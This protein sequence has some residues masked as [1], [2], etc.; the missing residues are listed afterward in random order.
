M[1][2]R[3]GDLCIKSIKELPMG[4]TKL[5]HNRVA[6]GEVTGHAHTLLGNDFELYQD[7]KGTMYLHIEQPTKITHQEH[8]TKELEKGFY[9]VEV[10]K[11]YCPFEDEIRKVA[12]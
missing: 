11:E 5:N 6:E 2:Y 7:T 4:L 10:E 9:I 8:K 1:I 3:H 12:D